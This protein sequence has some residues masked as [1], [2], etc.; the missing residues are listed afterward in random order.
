MTADVAEAPVDEIDIPTQMIIIPTAIVED[1]WGNRAEL[2]GER[3]PADGSAHDVAF[4]APGHDPLPA[5]AW[6]II[7]IDLRISI[8]T[9]FPLPLE[10]YVRPDLPDLGDLGFLPIGGRSYALDLSTRILTFGDDGAAVDTTR[11]TVA[12]RLAWNDIHVATLGFEPVE[13]VPVLMTNTLASDLSL[14]PGDT[15]VLNVG[16]ASIDATLV[17]TIPYAPGGTRKDAILAD[18]D[19][20]SRALLSGGGRAFITDA[21]WVGD[22]APGSA[23]AL[24]AAGLRPV[25]SRETYAETLGNGPR[26]AVR[27]SWSLLVFI[28]AVAL[29]IAGT[30]AQALAAARDRSLV[31]ARLRGMGVPRR[32]VHATAILE[33]V[34]VTVLAIA[35][36]AALGV[37]LAW[38]V[39]PHLV[40]G[41]A[42]FP[43][44]PIAR[45]VWNAPSLAVILGA[46]VVGG[47]VVGLPASRALA[48]RATALSLRQGDAS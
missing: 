26:A 2:E 19:A 5:G 20:I 38:L 43:S 32:S 35:C 46:F 34:A 36:G 13:S 41:S 39:A 1:E 40:T 12:F 15:F 6:S 7:A 29:A 45:L 18:F 21:W 14:A 33:H 3:L 4:P 27:A 42:D 37:A 31:A 48:Q 30:A 11:G 44:P 9:D 8:D 10:Y 25:E 28:A 24:E 23:D 47:T 16:T 17:G 22:P